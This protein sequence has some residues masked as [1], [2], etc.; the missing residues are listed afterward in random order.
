MLANKQ[1]LLVLDNCEHLIGAA[2]RLVGTNRTR[3]PGVVVLATSRE[4][5]AVDGE[6]LIA[7]PPLEAGAPSDD[8]DRL[9]DTDAVSLFVERARHVKADFALTDAN[10]RPSWRSANVSTVSRWPSSWPPRAS[11]RWVPANSRDGSI[12]DSRY[13][14]A[15][16]G[17]PSNGMRRFAPPSTGHTNCSTLP[18]KRL[19]ARMA[20]FSGGCTLEAIEEVCSGDPVDATKTSGPRD[21]F[22]GSVA[23]GS[24]RQFGGAHASACWRPSASTARNVLSTGARP[25]RLLLRHAPYYA[26]L[27]ARAAEHY[28]GPEQ[29]VWARQINLERD[30]IRSALAAAIDARNAALAVRLV[31]NHPHHHGY[32]GTGEVFEIDVPASRVLELADARGQTGYPRVLMAA[33]WHA[34][35]RGDYDRADELSRQAVEADS[36]V[37]DT[38][39]RPR[40]EM[41]A[42][43][44]KAMASLA[45]GA[46]TDAVSAYGRA[47]ELA[48]ADGY[49]GLAAIGLAVGVNTALLGGADFAT[50]TARAEEALTLARQS[51]M[52]AAIV[53]SLNSLALTLVE[54]DPIRARALLTESIERID[55]PDEAS[56][57]G[58]LTAC[59]VAGRLADWDLTLALVAPVDA[60]GA[61]GPGPDAARSLPGTLCARSRRT[62]ARDGRSPARCGV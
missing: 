46:Y 27:S 37:P 49:P 58:V 20:V 4:G 11:S 22:G 17:A 2:A 32:G 41:D 38:T 5:L 3:V 14:P 16:A 48:A 29:I 31:A 21:R 44:L 19:L 45:A 56:P 10:A 33:A 36:P 9:R 51:G 43:N 34:Y 1:L 26:D 47:A 28:Y 23:G 59:L 40:V 12:A 15:D 42:C 7:L 52:H 39:R 6:Q 8:L 62:P 57:S 25:T 24:R 50:V 30:N 35:V 53:M 60:P 13:W 61:L 18:N 54:I 55:I